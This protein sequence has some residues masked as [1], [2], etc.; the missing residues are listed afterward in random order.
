MCSPALPPRS[1]G[2]SAARRTQRP[3]R[4]AT[5]TPPARRR[6]R[7]WRSAASSH[8]YWQRQSRLTR[9]GREPARQ[10]RQPRVIRRA[11]RSSRPRSGSASV[12]A[13][14]RPT[15]SPGSPPPCACRGD[16]LF[17]AFL[18][19]SPL[20]LCPPFACRSP[21]SYTVSGH[22][23]PLPHDL[24]RRQHRRML[25]TALPPPLYPSFPSLPIPQSGP[26]ADTVLPAVQVAI[27]SRARAAQQRCIAGPTRG[28]VPQGP[29]A[30]AHGVRSGQ[31]AGHGGG[32]PAGRGATGARQAQA[33]P[34]GLAAQAGEDA[35]RG[36][37]TPGSRAHTA[38][39]E[40]RDTA[41]A[42]HSS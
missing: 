38:A 11:P 39:G 35:G 13:V 16:F 33:E 19:P 34:T 36:E 1:P 31:G 8:R 6:P 24:H 27:G 18:H 32:G 42:L 30:A 12:A 40:V 26:E 17:S 14:W 29:E 10:A 3:R 9:P 37:H 2:P 28:Q 4:R 7:G 21:R 22:A 41:A 5:V 15:R 25:M 20:G 23:L